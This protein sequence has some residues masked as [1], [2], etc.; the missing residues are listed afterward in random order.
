MTYYA[1][2]ALVNFILS[3]SL[4]LIV[5]IKNP[6]KQI[7]I[8]FALFAFAVALWSFSYFFWQ[9]SSSKEDAIAWLKLLMAFAIFIPAFYLHL[10][11]TLTNSS[12]KYILAISY[13]IFSIF[14]LFDLLT[15]LFIQGTRPLLMFGFWP[16][17]GPIF[18]IFLIIW[19]GIVIYSTYLL[20][21][22]QKSSNGLIKMQ[23]KYLLWGMIIGFAGGSTNYFLWYGILIPPVG[24]ILVSLYIGLTAYAIVRHS[25]LD[26]RLV[27]ARTVSFALLVTLI[28]LLYTL[29][30]AFLSYAFI[31]VTFELRVITIFTLLT[32][33]VSFSF[34]PIHRALEK[35]TDKLF[36]KDKYDTSKLLYD[37]ALVMAS[38]LELKDLASRLIETLI[39]QIRISRGMFILTE[40]G[41]I[42]DVVYQGYQTKPVLDRQ[43]ISSLLT[44]SSITIF[45]ELPEGD[46]KNVMREEGFMVVI[47]LYTKGEDVDLLVLG[48]KLSG[49]IYTPEDIRVLNIIAPEATVAIQNAKAYEE[50]RRFNIT[51]QE[52]VDKAT[53]DLQVT[54]QR[55]KE[56]DKLK[57][58]FVSVTSH[59]LRTPMTAIRSY[60]WMAL[61]KSDVPLSER[62]KKY[63]IRTL[64]S[65]ERL[66]N[67]VNDMLNVS[68]IESGRIEIIPE[69]V[70]LISLARDI[71]DEAYHSK[72]PQKNIEILLLEDS[73]PKV[74]ADPEKLREVFLNILGNAVKFTP[75]GGTITISF[76]TD[77][78]VVETSIKDSGVGISKEDLGRLFQKFGRLDNSYV[79]TASSGG[80]GL[81]LY[82]SKSLVELMH[83]RIWVS[84]EGLGKGATFTVSLPVASQEVLSRADQFRVRV[85]GEAKG[86]EPVAI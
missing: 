26:I 33:L 5:F 38:T 18:H 77:G 44:L 63:L 65:T 83:G 19:A 71:I 17:P 14:F 58:D 64:L 75:S 27:I 82:I 45:E 47:P 10:V 7:N 84:S 35:I 57:D 61:H 4:G 16:I 11:T 50:I 62:L 25:F 20:Y 8:T 51:L 1:T 60:T 23:T 22:S 70:D 78:K 32:L 12:N 3:L 21:L 72:A 46:M 68:R 6:K 9:I 54:N 2:S 43:K 73:I 49:D 79:S 34:Q 24:N 40:K 31:G 39:S 67:L 69:G 30:F 53:K 86:L 28:G 42:Y 37:L 48:E 41:H 85:K 55:L 74:F 29:L 56:L 66:I 36:Y 76:F 80:T 81:G 15:S 13:L 59:E 52:E